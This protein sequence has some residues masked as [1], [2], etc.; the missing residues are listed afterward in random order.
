M[1]SEVLV[2]FRPHGDFVV[3]E[4]QSPFK[5][6]NVVLRSVANAKVVHDESEHDVACLMFEEARSISALI[7]AMASE[8]FYESNLRQAAGLWESVHA[9]ANFEIDEAAMFHAVKVVSEHDFV[10]NHF[11]RDAKILISRGRER[12][13]QI[14]ICDVKCASFFVAG[15]DRVYN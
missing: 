11:E 4:F 8:V 5:M 3:V 15:H 10:G 2:P 1:H 13:A 6:I 12:C 14:E 9:L 7:V